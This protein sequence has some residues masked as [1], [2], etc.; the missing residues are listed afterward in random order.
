VSLPGFIQGLCLGPH[1]DLTVRRRG[2]TVPS[3]RIGS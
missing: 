1:V 3:K 2:V